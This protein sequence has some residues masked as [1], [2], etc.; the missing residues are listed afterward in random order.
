MWYASLSNIVT[1]YYTEGVVMKIVK[2]LNVILLAAFICCLSASTSYASDELAL[3]TIDST[4]KQIKA[5]ILM[6]Y[7]KQNIWGVTVTGSD[8][9]QKFKAQD[10]TVNTPA[11]ILFP[12]ENGTLC[13]NA[14]DMISP[15]SLASSGGNWTVK[16][17]EASDVYEPLA[18]VEDR[19]AAK[20]FEVPCMMSFDLQKQMWAFC[21]DGTRVTRTLDASDVNITTPA[22]EMLVFEGSL[23]IYWGN[24]DPRKDNLPMQFLA[25]EDGSW[26]IRHG[27]IGQ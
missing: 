7:P 15:I 10:V 26:E 23:W 25:Y 14:G 17:T 24:E 16:V 20:T 13:I 9:E 3:I 2:H 12:G 1:R 5:E 6:Y 11:G 19:H 22:G 4:G 21:E 27:L 18:S 8:Q